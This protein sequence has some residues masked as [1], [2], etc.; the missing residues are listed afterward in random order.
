MKMITDV[1]RYG[2][3]LPM[4]FLDEMLDFKDFSVGKGMFGAITPEPPGKAS[5]LLRQDE[6]LNRKDMGFYPGSHL[7]TPCFSCTV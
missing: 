5:V 4:T 3:R 1:L 6:D 2:I 7:S